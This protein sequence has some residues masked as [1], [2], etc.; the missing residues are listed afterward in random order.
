MALKLGEVYGACGKDCP[1][2][3]GGFIKWSAGPAAGLTLLDDVERTVTFRAGKTPGK[4]TLTGVE[5]VTG[6]QLV[7]HAVQIVPLADV[8]KLSADA[9]VALA[10]H[11]GEESKILDPAP[12]PLSVPQGS[13]LLVRVTAT[14]K[15]GQQVS[16]WGRDVNWTVEGAA[17]VAGRLPMGGDAD[18]AEGPIFSADGSGKVTLVGKVALLARTVRL[19]L[20]ITPAP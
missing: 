2:I 16:V 6:K 9:M 1:L 14:T 20:T 10:K 7:D 3:G 19:E 13:L 4:V 5:P 15:A 11:D 18:P 12:A 17:G 8:V